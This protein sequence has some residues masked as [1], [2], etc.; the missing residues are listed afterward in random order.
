MAGGYGGSSG[1]AALLG[2]LGWLVLAV[3]LSGSAVAAPVD[4]PFP[5]DR[6]FQ[7]GPDGTEATDFGRIDS[8]AVDQQSEFV[9]V[10][11][12]D[13]SGAVLSKFDREGDP[14]D[15]AGTSSYIDGNRIT[16]LNAFDPS[17]DLFTFSKSTQVAVDPVSHVI[18]V[19]E[20]DAI[21][22]FEANGEPA[23]FTAGPGAGS[24][25]IPG[26][27]QL[28]SVAVDVDGSIYAVD[29]AGTVSVFAATGAALTSFAVTDPYNVSVDSDGTVYVLEGSTVI[30]K[31]TPGPFPV[32]EGTVYSENT[33]TSVPE[34]GSILFA[35]FEADRGN[36]DLYVLETNFTTTWIR[37]YDRA[38][39]VVESFG[40]PGT[41]TESSAFGGPSG[42]IAVWAQGKEIAAGE[43]IKLYVGDRDLST[44]PESSKVAAVGRKIIIGPP[45]I[46]NTSVLDVTADSARLRAWID[47]NTA[48]TT[49]RFEY[50]IEDCAVSACTRV[51]LGGSSVTGGEDPVE[52]SQSIFGLQPG[53]TY[54]YR[55]VAENSFGP[56][57]GPSRAF[58]TQSLG[59]GFELIDSRVW[60]MVSPP[61]KR[62]AQ[63]KATKGGMIRAAADGGALAYLTQGTI[64]SDPQGVRTPE[65]SSVLARRSPA[66]WISQD[67]MSPNREV[68]PAGTETEG[69][70]KL[71]SPDLLSA[72][73]MPR[74]STPLSPHASER[75]PYLWEH[76]EPPVYTPLVTGKEGFA[77]V[78]PDTEFGGS[79]DDT[80]GKVIPIGATPDLS[81][82]VLQARLPASLVAGFP[83][84]DP[85]LALYLW[86]AGQ[87]QPVSVLP[88][89]EGGAMAPF[90]PAFG[91][92]VTSLQHAISADGSR[93]F[94]G[95]LA[96][97]G[98]ALYL[99]D[100]LAEETV[101]LDVVQPDATG[102]GEPSPVFQGASADGTAVF[103][104][105]TRQLTP[106]ASATGR[107]LYRCEI[108]LGDPVAG[109]SSL[110][111][112]SVPS[113][114]P[115]ESGEMLGMV[116]GLSEDGT[117][118]YFVARG[119]LDDSSN[120]Y[121]DRALPGD[122]NLYLWEEGGGVLFVSTLAE[123]DKGTWGLRNS[124]NAF[125]TA[126]KLSAA[127]SPSGRYLA[128][129]S[130]LSLTG[131]ANLDAANGGPVQ[132]VFRYD[133]EA[134][135]LG[136]L[137][138][139]PFGAAPEAEDLNSRPLVNPNGLYNGLRG[140]AT[141]PAASENE[142]RF[143]L[144]RARTALDNGRVFFNAFDA[145]VPAD[146][147]G[148]WDVYQYE[149]TGVG[150]CSASSGDGGTARSAGG[151]VSLLS[152]ATGE[153][154]SGFLDSSASG[155]DV[156]FLT[157][158]RLSVTDEDD[159]LDVYDARVNG[160]A[161]IRQPDT[162]CEGESC[163]PVVVAPGYSPSGSASLKSK[164]NVIQKKGKRCPKGKRKVYRKG[165]VHCVRKHRR[166]HQ[167]A[168][169]NR[170]AA[171]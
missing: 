68:I 12:G 20:T 165:K 139:N 151:C 85:Y 5:L 83:V 110:T 120:Q 31:F 32:S 138:C 66:G 169:Q 23:A 117:R 116:A 43:T 51:P 13:G 89:D 166:H 40:A 10:L 108:P 80:L 161:A 170:R 100:M 11:T 97:S 77:N 57:P 26:F 2:L 36:G 17:F 114:S 127:I 171:R 73:L 150:G 45:E 98:G 160:V 24:S 167:K 37:R 79:E 158:A 124:A 137:S 9:Y 155:D 162:Q 142:L 129:M 154:E 81:H 14:V 159:Q 132:E 44:D 113:A 72:I 22:A 106:D 75:T 82:V 64:D 112:L 41:P 103:F 25:E 18:Y 144:Y 143:S 65:Y 90:E 47:P 62:G 60:E 67:I 145:L 163:R 49:Y 156:F 39:L 16:G 157:P 53:T 8:V 29:R 141:L 69:E 76:S 135:D 34:A 27:T 136:C 149:P 107:D 84:Q 92:N 126:A 30:K 168:S 88:T 3:G 99:R 94:W 55:V 131:Y 71:F 146:S 101:R 111:N 122:P 86:T 91:S 15:F 125:G 48:E 104:S 6:L 4:Q 152:S 121:G 21:R 78:P 59:L 87:L 56:T 147:N 134:D 115:G 128:F 105:D 35:G 33:F 153:E 50:G 54:F 28:V 118:V 58:T 95:Q 96:D 133:A 74:G 164:G 42:G 140:A 63:L 123:E 46:E 38:G 61:N 148:E 52:V 7:F 93:V 119:V 102:A 130:Q 109:C 19:T 1:R 70:F